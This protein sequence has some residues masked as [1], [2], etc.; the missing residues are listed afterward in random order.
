M[1]TANA[2]RR[3]ELPGF[4]ARTSA[5]GGSRR[6]RIGKKALS[7]SF[8]AVLRVATA[9]S[10]SPAVRGS[11]GWAAG[12]PLPRG[13]G[14]VSTPTQPASV[15]TMGRIAMFHL[16][17]FL[18]RVRRAIREHVPTASASNLAGPGRQTATDPDAG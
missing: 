17:E 2:S 13:S 10:I 12:P 11:R 9:A 1:T 3:N 5:F 18:L 15:I 4:Q 7:G 16:I 6:T 14:I 8:P